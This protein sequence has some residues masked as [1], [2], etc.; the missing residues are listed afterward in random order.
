MK[1]EAPLPA[2]LALLLL[3]VVPFAAWFLVKPVRLLVPQLAPVSCADASVCVDDLSRLAGAT[4]LYAEATGFVANA[5]SPIRGAPKVIFCTTQA[6]ADYFGLGARSAVTLGKF[7][8]V[9]GPKAW[10]PYYVRHEMIHYLQAENIGVLP[11]LLKPSWF[12]EG[13]AYS[14]SQDPRPTLAE[15]FEGYRRSFVSWYAGV[16]KERVWAE[17]EKL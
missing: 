15:P 12:V 11:L 9:I 1:L 8:T 2:R 13:M 6:C 5:I 4:G 10:L 3:V 14:L 17:A 16:G 7:G